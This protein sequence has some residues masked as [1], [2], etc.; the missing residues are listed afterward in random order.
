M[1]IDFSAYAETYGRNRSINPLVLAHL[2]EGTDLAH[3]SS[4]LE[5][6]CGTAN[7]LH[8]IAEITGAAGCGVDPSEGML[9]VAASDPASAGLTLKHG[10]A[11]RLPFADSSF[12][13][14]F[15]VDVMHHIGDRA[16][17]AT[18]AYRVLKRGG[19]FLA[20]TDS[21]G[22]LANRIPLASHFPATIANE[23]SR[24]PSIELITEDLGGAGFEDVSVEQVTYDY[25]LSDATPYRERAYSA[26]RQL[27]DAQ[28]RAG[29]A[30][31]EHDLAI[32][33]LPARS[34]YTLIWATKPGSVRGGK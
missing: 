8:A 19:K 7:Y 6:G 12:E 29:L 30:R 33:P 23:L 3:S 15:S 31:L 4:V 18:E 28:F 24:Y 34:L 5:V 21:H 11:E 2:V 20:A 32:G 9:A 1:T 25:D 27:T 26:L 10:L 13:V 16:A 14:V 22:D 17:A